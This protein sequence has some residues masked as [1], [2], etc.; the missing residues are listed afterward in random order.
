MKKINFIKKVTPLSADTFNQ[1][2][3]N[4]EEEFSQ[5][6]SQLAEKASQQEVINAL[7]LKRDKNVKLELED[8]SSNVLSAI[9][10]GEGTTFNLLSIPQDK[11]VTVEKTNFVKRGKNK[12]DGNFRHGVSVGETYNDGKYPKAVSVV[13]HATKL[14]TYTI[15]KSNDTDR[16]VISTFI[17]K[18]V[19]GQAYV[20]QILAP[21]PYTIT[22][23]GDEDYIV[24]QV[25]SSSQGLEPAWLQIEEGNKATAFSGYDNVEL[26]LTEKSVTSKMRTPIGNAAYL[27][28]NGKPINF[29]FTKKILEF[30]SPLEAKYVNISTGSY[31]KLWENTKLPDVDLTDD[32]NIVNLGAIYYNTET[33]TFYASRL[34]TAINKNIKTT[35]NSLLIA[36]YYLADKK[37][38]MNG[39]YL[40]DGGEDDNTDNTFVNTQENINTSIVIATK[41]TDGTELIKTQDPYVYPLYPVWGHEY[42]YSWYKKI[43]NNKHLTMVW[44]GDS[45]TLGTGVLD[46]NYQRHNLAKK[47]MTLGGYNPE[48]ITSINA[49]HGSQHTATWLGYADLDDETSDDITPVGGFLAED[50]SRN[51]DLY[52]IGY[53]LNDGSKNH[54][55]GLTWQEKIDGF[56]SR[57]REGLGRIRTNGTY[58]SGPSY[59]KSADELAIIIC[60]PTSSNSA[61]G[62]QTP[63]SWQDR[64][65]P[66]IQ[67][68]CRDFKCA[69][70][71]FTARQYDHAFSSSWSGNGDYVHPND[72]ANADY[73]SM[74]ADLLF[75]LLLHK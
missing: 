1:M 45:T 64:I 72:I 23:E 6:N 74:L 10:G 75:P 63:Q 41:K 38:I 40:V 25:S 36:I 17:G 19:R 13:F 15:S 16:F 44:V 54:F 52:V 37:V 12:F 8:F 29:N 58:Q 5:V 66:I 57:L 11:S 62:G 70:V 71:D 51:P 50:M 42:M 31:N 7:D 4:I 24:V 55:K 53:G 33:E 61:N 65:R 32:G 27:L 28:T 26:N 35:E 60:M 49:G 47:I 56:E 3:N 14:Q 68:A 2:Q 39:N 43:F 73:M 30:P 69:F 21:N 34:S 18:P 22:L 20:R 67:R 9:Q 59:N 48:L 46:V